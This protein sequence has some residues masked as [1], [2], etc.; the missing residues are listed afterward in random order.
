MNPKELTIIEKLA[1]VEHV[2]TPY[3]IYSPNM[4]ELNDKDLYFE[5]FFKWAYFTRNITLLVDEAMEVSENP[6]SIP[7]HYKGILT[8]GRTRD[9]SVWSCTQRPA[10][11]SPMIIS[12]SKHIFMFN[13][14]KKEDR[15]KIADS[16][17]VPEFMDN[18]SGHY[19]WY[20]KDGMTEAAKGILK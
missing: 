5:E 20:W 14:R 7:R 15:K 12:Q 18:P 4:D 8:R 11:L 10:G 9:V 3:F 1:D 17:G 13:L 6:F 19:F 2:E 16:T